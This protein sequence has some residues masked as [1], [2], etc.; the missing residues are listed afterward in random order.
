MLKW[1]E[2][3]PPTKRLAFG[4]VAIL[5]VP[6]LRTGY[7]Q[8]RPYLPA[9]QLDADEAQNFFYQI[10]RRRRSSVIPDLGINR[11]ANWAV[12]AF[13]NAQLL[14]SPGSASVVSGEQEFGCVVQLDINSVPD[15]HSILSREVLPRLFHEFVEFAHEIIAEGD[16]P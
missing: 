11:L 4:V 15:Y 5:P 3:A 10:N 13:G 2:R 8:L 9:V 1:L 7:L 16:I 14:L 12:A 6:D